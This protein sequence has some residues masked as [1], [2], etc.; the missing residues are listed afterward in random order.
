MGVLQE[1]QES[2]CFRIPLR[3]RK[4]LACSAVCDGVDLT[5]TDEKCGINIF[6]IYTILWPICILI[7]GD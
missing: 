2:V 6:P 1:E 5:E 7:R 4:S 3:N